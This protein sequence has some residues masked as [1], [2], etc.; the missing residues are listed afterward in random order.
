MYTLLIVDDTLINLSILFDFFND[1][2]FRMLSATNGSTALRRAE[3]T[4]PD[5]ILLDIIMPDM[6][7]FEVCRR[8]KRQAD[9]RDI[10]VIF[11]TALSGS[12]DKIQGFKLGAVDYITK[13]FEY[14]EV[15]A[16]VNTQLRLKKQK[17]ML[18]IQNQTLSDINLNL[19]ASKRESDQASQAKS[20]FLANMSHELRTPMNAIL[21]YSEMLIEDMKLNQQEDYCED[22]YKI[23]QAGQHLLNLINNVLDFSKIEAGKMSIHYE[24]IN[25]N[26]L[27]MNVNST[28]D[29]LMKQNNNQF[30]IECKHENLL[31]RTDGTKLQ[32]VLLNL[33]GNAAK[34]TQKGNIILRIEKIRQL[35]HEWLLFQVED[36]GIGMDSQQQAKIFGS[37]VQASLSTPSQYG[38]TGLGLSISKQIS[39]LLGGKLSVESQLGMGSTFSLQLPVDPP[40]PAPLRCKP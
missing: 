3:Q 36:N 13:P 17:E 4:K 8:L 21:G 16:R 9:T 30:Q 40:A 29:P 38:G 37:F 20:L 25:L 39:Q 33:L 19:R 12:Q 1:K 24:N 31:L 11:M 27:I 22:L 35:E 15:L 32:Q 5:L 6:D 23:N 18:E 2:D 7:G 10:P 14:E 28:I 26:E 34:F